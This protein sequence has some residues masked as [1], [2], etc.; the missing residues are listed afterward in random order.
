MRSRQNYLILIL[1]FLLIFMV[2]SCYYD[3]EEYLYPGDGGT[4][5]CDTTNITYSGTIAPILA[6]AC[7][8]CHYPASSF[9]AGISVSTYND[10]V[11]TINNGRF[12]GAINHSSGYSPMPK[13]GSKLSNCNLQKI[14][15]WIDDEA[16]NN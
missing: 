13:G 5:G 12:I 14:Q 9:G 8:G 10:L 2:T 16:L 7:N 1:S 4:T 11:A 15:K 6:N 3:N